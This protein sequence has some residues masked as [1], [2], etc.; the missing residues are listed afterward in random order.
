MPKGTFGVPERK[1]PIS[2]FCFFYSLCRR[3]LIKAGFPQCLYGG[4]VRP[5]TPDSCGGSGKRTRTSG[6]VFKALPFFICSSSNMPLFKLC[7]YPGCRRAVPLGEKYCEAH[8][9]KGEA[10]DA[11]SAK[12]RESRRLKFKGT[13]ADRGYDYRWRKLRN[14]FIAQHPHCAECLKRGVITMATDVD[15][16][17]PHRGDARLLYDEANLQ[18]LCKSCHSKKT[19]SEDGGF[20]NRFAPRG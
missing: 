11:L 17:I 4:P 1:S 3:S 20:G 8:K 10:Q 13:S 6:R 18:S 15:H 12:Q 2:G 16:I 5:P 7:A 9:Q 19:A 14:R